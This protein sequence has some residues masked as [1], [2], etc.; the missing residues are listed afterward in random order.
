MLPAR[1]DR[2]T[3]FP[4]CGAQ[5]PQVVACQDQMV[6]ALHRCM[7]LDCCDELEAFP[8]YG[9]DSRRMGDILTRDDVRMWHEASVLQSI[10]LMPGMGDTA[11]KDA[12]CV[13][14]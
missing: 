1:R 13:S 7:P 9:T 14:T 4:I 12:K 5:C 11:D 3:Q 10:T 8:S 2:K 6:D